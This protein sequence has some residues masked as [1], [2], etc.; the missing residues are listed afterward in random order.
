MP[1]LNPCALRLLARQ[2]GIIT[3]PQCLRCGN[4][5]DAVDGEVRRGQLQVVHCGTYR[6]TGAPVP[7]Q[8]RAMA[9]VLRCRP[10][11]CLSGPVVLAALGV[12]GFSFDD[13]LVVVV[14]RRRQVRNVPFRVRRSDLPRRERTRIGPLPTARPGYAM[15]DVAALEPIK[16][17]L[18]GFDALRWKRL[19]DVSRALEL[20]Q[21]FPRHPGA[22]VIV[23]LVHDGHL[24]Q[25]SDG[26]RRLASVAALLA[27]NIDWQ[28][29]VTPGRRVD[30]LIR[31]SCL[32]LEYLGQEAH[33]GV[34]LRREDLVRDAEIRAAGYWVLYVTDRDM[35]V[36]DALRARILAAHERCLRLLASGVRPGMPIAL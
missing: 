11:A 1:P 32:A 13:E 2:F 14:P 34:L 36:P 4:T 15:L 33:D 16:R 21:A 22:R 7:P 27:L 3:R 24:Q 26:E 18:A 28:V 35:S 30:G 8:Q 29:W 20:A 19:L 23:E 25:Q 12:E 5:E 17:V 10:D 9:A 31:P 6:L